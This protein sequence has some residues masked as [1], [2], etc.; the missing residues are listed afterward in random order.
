MGY[1]PNPYPHV[2]PERAA[3]QTEAVASP[4]AGV[5]PSDGRMELTSLTRNY[6]QLT[7]YRPRSRITWPQ[8]ISQAQSHR[9]QIVGAM[10]TMGN[11]RWYLRCNCRSFGKS[12]AGC[13]QGG[14]W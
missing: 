3:V 1:A 10:V 4:A 5:S 6:L 2:L 11:Q 13:Y 8:R 7:G 12:G 9:Q 14:V